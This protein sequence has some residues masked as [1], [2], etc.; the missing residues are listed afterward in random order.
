M[1]RFFPWMLVCL[2]LALEIRVTS[3]GYSRGEFVYY[4]S[5]VSAILNLLAEGFVTLCEVVQVCPAF[6][7]PNQ[8]VS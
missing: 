7:R 4:I 3:C 1:A 6:K 8:V 2:V 5:Y